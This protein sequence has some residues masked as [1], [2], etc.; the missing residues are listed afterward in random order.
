V[1]P[2]GVIEIC[3]GVFGG[4]EIIESI[5]IPESVSYIGNAAFSNC[6]G[7]RIIKLPRN[8]VM[9]NGYTFQN[10][11]CLET[12]VLSDN[13]K[14][15]GEWAFSRTRLTSVILPD[16]VTYLANYAFAGCNR[17]RYV[18][19]PPTVHNFEKEIFARC[20]KLKYVVAGRNHTGIP[21]TTKMALTIGMWRQYGVQLPFNNSIVCF[22]L[23]MK[24]YRLPLEL[25]EYIID[26]ML[27]DMALYIK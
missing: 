19:I 15:V 21:Y 8:L 22:M 2:P 18:Y 11:S 27:C 3:D 24:K 9:I 5:K 14:C 26:I 23:V 4:C 17:L 25:V 7:L 16:G 12:C 6:K 1:I 20:N 10:C 13:L